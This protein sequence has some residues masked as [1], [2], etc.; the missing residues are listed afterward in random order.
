MSFK[1]KI[2][3]TLWYPKSL[4]S[5]KT[6]V[7]EI[8]AACCDNIN[9]EC[10]TW[11][12]PW[13]LLFVRI[14]KHHCAHTDLPQYH[15]NQPTETETPCCSTNPGIKHQPQ[16]IVSGVTGSYIETATNKRWCSGQLSRALANEL[17]RV[18]DVPHWE[19]SC[20][21]KRGGYGCGGGCWTRQHRIHSGG[22]IDLDLIPLEERGRW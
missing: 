3:F 22:A 1:I 6:Q 4:P 12:M 10:S 21:L 8:K 13:E 20:M 5:Y 19:E 16:P 17:Q 2:T 18:G 11:S 14:L 7:K 15:G 9:S